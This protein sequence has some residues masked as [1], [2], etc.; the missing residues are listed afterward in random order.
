M[1][2]LSIITINYNN[3]EGLR[4]TID[5]VM[6]QHFRDVEYIMIDGGS[7]DGSRE[8][9]E[10][11]AQQF[12]YWIS[13]KDGGIYDALNK[14]IE[15][16]KGKYCMFLNSGDFLLRNDV[17]DNAFAIIRQQELDVYYGDIELMFADG[18]KTIQHHA[19]V[20]DLHFLEKRTLNHQASFIKR[21][22][23]EELG[24][25]N[26]GYSLAADYAFY[27]EAFLKG[28]QFCYINDVMV[29]YKRDGISST[30][31]SAYLQQMNTIWNKL[32]PLP[33]Q[34]LLEENK[35]HRHND[36]KVLVRFGKQLD[37]IYQSLKIKKKG[38]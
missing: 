21:T 24:Q 17:L 14:G 31:M 19:P 2:D 8:L 35:K 5:S 32:V 20:L 7:T 23:F 33:V 29:H 6:N 13:E 34:Q 1:P 38:N 16:A 22:L 4:S 10:T 9:I 11:N 25:Y 12:S 3:L 18:Q 37:R 15:Q 26:T 28:K 30:N 36:K 27:L